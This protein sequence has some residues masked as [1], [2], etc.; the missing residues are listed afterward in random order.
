[1]Y[2]QD[3]DTQKA[4]WVTYDQ[5][6]DDWTRGYL[7]EN[8][9]EASKYVESAAGSKYNSGYTFAAEAPLKDIPNF[10]A[11]LN[12]DTITNGEHNVSFTIIPK[13]EVDVIRLYVDKSI[14]FNTLAYN[15][16]SV[17]KDSTGKVYSN[18]VNNGLI[19]YYVSPND[20]LQIN[21]SVPKDVDVTFNVLEYSF[22][23]LK[24]PLF[25]IA[26]RPTNTMTKPFV[27]TDAI[28]MKRLINPK[29]LM[30]KVMDSTVTEA[31]E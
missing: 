18:R 27:F 20:T 1:M 21:Y 25:T 24:N 6:L 7:G 26:E 30:Q 17:A 15:G 9:E 2:Y 28:V 10:E 14:V 22:D 23:L 12:N 5:I 4:Y 19:S 31:V 3:T 29:N 11:L 8:P 13:R 16:K